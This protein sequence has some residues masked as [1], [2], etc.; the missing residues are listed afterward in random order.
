MSF[1]GNPPARS[2]ATNAE[3]S[4]VS[5]ASH[6]L[7]FSGAAC[8]VGLTFGI[9]VSFPPRI[10][11]GEA[12]FWADRFASS[13]RPEERARPTKRALHNNDSPRKRE[14]RFMAIIVSP[15]GP[16]RVECDSARCQHYFYT[17]E[18]P[19]PREWL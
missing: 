11:E 15:P 19:P 3:R 5:N 7:A 16:A 13:E 18:A 14:S 8:D 9:D 12:L 6:S 2:R 10:A 4:F 1:S 17:E